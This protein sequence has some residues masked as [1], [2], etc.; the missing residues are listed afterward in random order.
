[1]TATEISVN[2]F[3]IF[4]II[5]FVIRRNSLKKNRAKKFLMCLAIAATT[6]TAVFAS[7]CQTSLNLFTIPELN[8]PTEEK[9]ALK[10]YDY[11]NLSDVQVT[12]RSDVMNVTK[13]NL[14]RAEAEILTDDFSLVYN[15]EA[16]TIDAVYGKTQT[17]D[18]LKTA[19]ITFTDYPSPSHTCTGVNAFTDGNMSGAA[20]DSSNGAFYKYMLMTQGQHLAADAARFSA[21]TASDNAG[22]DQT[23]KN[24]L[25]KHPSADAQYGE[26]LGTDNA[27][28][29]EITLDPL[30]RSPH[31]TGLYLLAGEAITIKVEGLK[32]GERIVVQTGYQNSLAWRGGVSDSVFNSITGGLNKVTT[33]SLDAYFTK[34]DVLVANN[35]MTEGSVTSQSQWGVKQNN[36]AP[37]VISDFTLTENKTYTIGTSF[38]GAL[39]ISMGN[40]Y[41][42]VK[43][44]IT[45]AVETPHY[46][47]GVTTPEYFDQYLR[48]APGVIAVLDT[49][50]GQ[51]IG[52]TGEMGTTQ[53]MRQVKKEE[54]DK[55]AM[56]WHSFLSVNESFTGGT[57]NRFNK[58]MFDWHVPAG[59]AVAL[60]NY[61]FAQ[62][63]SWFN[64]AMNYRGL[65]A[66]GTWGTLHEIGHTHATSYGTVWGFATG[67]EGEVRNNALILLSYIMFCDVGTT[68]RN[69]GGAEHGA[70]ANPYNVLSETLSFKG[71]TGDFDDGSY[72]YFQCLGMYANI[73]HSFGA[74][75]F[76]ELLYTYKDAASYVAEGTKGNKRSDFTY[77]CSKVYGMDFRKYFNTFYCANIT[78]E[79]FTAEQRAEM[80]ALPDY[81]V[82]SSFYAGGIDG[83]KTSGDY[84]VAFGEDITFD[85][86][87]KTISTLDDKTAGTKGFEIVS[88]NQPEHGK[89]TDLGNGKWSYSFNKEYTGV[90]DTFTFDVRLSDGIIH[91]LSVYLRISYNGT[92]ITAYNDVQGKNLD[93]VMAD[94]SGK[95]PDSV[96]GNSHAY[97]PT[98]NSEK[99]KK[100]VRVSE[101]Y[102]RAPKSGEVSFSSKMD[103]WGKIYFGESF[104]TLEEIISIPSYTTSFNDYGVTRTVEQ[105]KF[106]AMKIFNV[107]AGG[108][109]SAVPGIKY[110]DEENYAAIADADAFH[111]DFPLGST[112]E[113]YVYEPQFI[114]SKKDSIKLSV[115]GT[116]KT[117][118]T[119]IKAP[120][121]VH[122]GRYEKQYQVDE[123]KDSPTYGQTI[124]IEDARVDKWTWLIDG[125]AGTYLHTS[126]GGEYNKDYP[127]CEK[128]SPE[129]PHEFIIDTSKSQQFNYFAVTTRNHANSYITD[130]E[131]QISDSADGGWRTIATGDRSNYVKNVLTV[132]FAEESGRY[133]RLLVKGTSGSSGGRQFSV[134]AEIDAG[135]ETTTQQV[136]PPTSNKF[137]ATDGWK[138]SSK[139]DTEP[140]GY[141]ITE[142]KNEKLVIKFEGEGIS[143]Y[144]ATGSGYGTADI[145]LDGKKAGVIDLNST[146]E[147]SRKLVFNKENLEN[148][149]H[150]VEIIT[151]SSEKV[152]INVLGIPYSANLVNA[153]NI[154]KENALTI[155]LVVFVILFAA[156][157]A[158]L[159]VLVFVPKFRRLVF[160]NRFMKKLDERENK[161]KKEKPVKNKNDGKAG[162]D[163]IEKDKEQAKKTE[164]VS[165]SAKPAPAK[166]AQQSSTVKPAAAKPVAKTAAPK[167]TAPETQTKPTTKTATVKPA[168]QSATV[169]PAAK[170]A[171]KTVKPASDKTQKPKK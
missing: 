18:N 120:E 32:P 150:T 24:W 27:V 50:N 21:N 47:L 81:E 108:G 5:Y 127:N 78:D 30:Y 10:K 70:Y 167:P 162:T 102:W 38:G 131:L 160:G 67:R 71:K 103:D 40:C 123:N 84:K 152:M 26:V 126:Y 88:V 146:A 117:E 106:Y 112:V 34:A 97:I 39:H 142:K 164:P 101:F 49:E 98:Y 45:G 95:Q 140:N 4:K 36:R 7:A 154:Y 94:V 118:W 29:K 63:T 6:V 114:V 163:E 31:F 53:Y 145:Y 105:G 3:R 156:V 130:F 52:Y 25:K 169:K 73:M 80:D 69:G 143:L 165:A 13:R 61:S 171:D 16:K 64:D 113:T 68:I 76:Y 54:I 12:V 96:I 37:W 42:R 91:R 28:E 148:K 159:A 107:N 129:H 125:Q 116:D 15:E 170:P 121:N 141:L 57:Y 58:I 74:E 166:P 100:D 135:I 110:S 48:Q 161:P 133:L 104:D 82:V 65:L 99:G 122:G 8:I 85:L 22:V 86:L 89:L 168:Q 77:R 35:K 109:G 83:V 51:L 72:G 155:A 56:L 60:G 149:E 92:R 23:F 124:E 20:V 139:I 144:A 55:L 132:K 19:N 17:T 79:M 41:S 115:S 128:I 14:P 157:I 62:P 43:T 75:K 119:V 66:R 136:I 11:E 9:F 151:T 134:L 1:M 44:T 59:A 93:E 138:N 153:A 90:S 147:E 87:E 111:P 46:I 137:F 158:V 2:V 33:H